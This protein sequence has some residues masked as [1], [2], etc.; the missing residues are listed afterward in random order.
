M[1]E[2]KNISKVFKL[3]HEKHKTFFHKLTGTLRSSFRYEEFY[4]L[5]NVSFNVNQG[6]FLG[7]VGRNGSGKTTLLRII[8]GIY[9]PTS[10]VVNV[11]EI[12]NTFLEIG[13]GFQ[14]DFTC[15]ENVYINGALLGFSRKEMD[16]R[17]SDI[18]HFAELEKFAD[19]KLIHL[20]SGMQV[21]LAFS[22]A[23]QVD[24]PIFLVDEIFAV[25]DNPFQQKCKKLF[26]EYKRQGKTVL[27]VSH[28]LDSILEYCDRVV[29]LE[30]GVLVKQGTPSETIAYYTKEVLKK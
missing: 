27:F 19:A 8:A 15:R 7:V 14:S 29:I 13:V 30:N 2:V 26:W 21:R 25:G 1:I 9:K 6:E 18:L 12:M 5:N 10:G 11:N 4:A 22:I 20:S 23:M 3:P 17:F 24:A 16:K 28:D